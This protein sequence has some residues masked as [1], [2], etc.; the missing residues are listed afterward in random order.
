M[1]PSDAQWQR[2]TRMQ[3]AICLQEC[4]CTDPRK[5]SRGTR[6]GIWNKVLRNCRG[7]AKMVRHQTLDLPV[8]VSYCHIC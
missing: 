6:N 8:I 1:L 7:V 2:N 3:V 5:D 4:W